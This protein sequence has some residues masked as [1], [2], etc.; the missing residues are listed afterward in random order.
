MQHRNFVKPPQPAP[1]LI[2]APLRPSSFRIAKTSFNPNLYLYKYPINLVA[3]ILLVQTTN[4][5]GA[6]CSGTSAHKIQTPG[7]HPNE[8]TQH[9][10]RLS[11]RMTWRNNMRTAVVFCSASGTRRWTG[12]RTVSQSVSQSVRKVSWLASPYNVKFIRLC[13]ASSQY[14]SRAHCCICLNF[15]RD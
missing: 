9:S 4:E 11:L 5:E 3:V 8:R 7:N 15:K 13:V 10:L 6:E 2:H 14:I 1:P 12:G